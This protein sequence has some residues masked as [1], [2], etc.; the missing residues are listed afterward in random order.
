MILKNISA[1]YGTK[2]KG[3]KK[4]KKRKRTASLIIK[5]VRGEK[6][7]IKREGATLTGR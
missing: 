6:K 2:R 5:R 1:T 7:K 3:E 4:K